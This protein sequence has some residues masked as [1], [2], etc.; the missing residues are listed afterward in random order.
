MHSQL[1]RVMVMSYSSLWGHGLALTRIRFS[2]SSLNQ[3]AKVMVL[4]LPNGQCRVLTKTSYKVRIIVLQEFD[5]QDHWYHS[6]TTVRVLVLL[7]CIL[8]RLLV[9][10]MLKLL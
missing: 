6:F 3:F 10:K 4:I 9:L 7:I 1:V 5:G 2:G 8:A